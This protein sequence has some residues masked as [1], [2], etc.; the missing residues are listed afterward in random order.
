MHVAAEYGRLKMLTHFNKNGGELSSRNYADELPIHMAAREGH[1]DI[2]AYIMEQTP[3]HIDVATI[4]GWTPF[5][6]AVNNGYLATIEFLISK[7]TNIN[8]IDKF[9]RTALHWAVRYNFKEIV[10]YLL[11]MNINTDIIDKEGRKAYEIAQA[12]V[13]LYML[14]IL[15]DHNKN[16]NKR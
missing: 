5:H 8:A 16:K 13:S 6:Y 12:A 1:I 9:G 4:D 7:G 11:E 10:E 14:N 15:S 2:I 3:I